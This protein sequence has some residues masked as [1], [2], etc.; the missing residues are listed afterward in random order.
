MAGVLRF[1]S[2][3]ICVGKME[4]VN[5]GLLRVR[6]VILENVQFYEKYTLFQIHARSTGV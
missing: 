6:N 2:H 1:I 3:F 4:S 5:H